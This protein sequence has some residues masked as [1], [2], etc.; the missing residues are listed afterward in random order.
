MHFKET[1]SNT[2]ICKQ[3]ICLIEQKKKYVWFSLW[4]SNH[5]CKSTFENAKIISW[6]FELTENPT[7]LL[8]FLTDRQCV[9]NF[10]NLYFKA[11]ASHVCQPCHSLEELWLFNQGWA[12]PCSAFKQWCCAHVFTSDRWIYL[13]YRFLRDSTPEALWKF[14]F[15]NTSK[16]SSAVTF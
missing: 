10:N 4:S 2:F 1:W 5:M 16:F 7:L 8:F 14:T 6:Y 13:H 12:F 3:L 11:S 9:I 15:L